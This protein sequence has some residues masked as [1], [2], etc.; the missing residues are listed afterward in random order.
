MAD[1]R[2]A[3]GKRK[4]GQGRTI[5]RG[6]PPR[7]YPLKHQQTWWQTVCRI[8]V[9][10]IRSFFPLFW[11]LVPLIRV[12]RKFSGVK[13]PQR[14]KS[15]TIETP[16]QDE[17]S[18]SGI[19]SDFNARQRQLS[20]YFSIPLARRQRSAKLFLSASFLNSFPPPW[21]L[22]L[23]ARSSKCLIRRQDA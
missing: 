23:S 9:A 5:S 7:H 12:S 2:P 8:A 22:R 15:M 14:P 20:Q 1:L 10:A 6:F 4:I 3:R 11:S 13:L 17:S 18:L 16:V 19:L 21:P